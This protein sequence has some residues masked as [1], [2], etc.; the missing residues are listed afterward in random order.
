MVRVAYL[1]AVSIGRALVGQLRKLWFFAALSVVLALSL[2]RAVLAADAGGEELTVA[3][4]M[5][6]R[7]S[8]PSVVAG[9]RR[10]N[11]AADVVV[12]YGASGNLRR[13]VEAGAPIDVVIFASAVHVDAL[14]DSGLI[15]GSPRVIASNALVLIGARGAKP[16]KFA[17]IDSVAAGDLIAIGDPESVPAGTYARD[18]LRALAKWDAVQDR[19]VFGGHV[20]AVLQYVRRGEVAVAVVYAS[21]VIGI[22][23]VV[24]LDTASGAWAPR[25]ETVAAAVAGNRP[26]A[27]RAFI[28]FLESPAGRVILT[29]HGFAAPPQPEGKSAP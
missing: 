21:D 26:E 22:D 24:V 5:S 16:M 3:A 8:L 18:A 20:A 12:T 25:I 7:N 27:A 19:L 11:A 23:D 28:E 29:E 17:E 1:L 6:L 9:F 15:A 13:Q 10:E 14:V 4:A 2:P